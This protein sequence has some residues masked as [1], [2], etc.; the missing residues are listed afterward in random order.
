MIVNIVH[1]PAALQQWNMLK[2]SFL[3]RQ[4]FELLVIKM[5]PPTE[6]KA[7]ANSEEEKEV[8]DKMDDDVEVRFSLSVEQRQKFLLRRKEELLQRASRY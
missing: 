7:G 4:V 2:H 6:D 8:E 3:S 1:K 5:T